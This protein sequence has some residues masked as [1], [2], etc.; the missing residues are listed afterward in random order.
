M[1]VK[2]QGVLYGKIYQEF[3]AETQKEKYRQILSI[4]KTKPK[5]KILDVAC[6]PGF[7][8]KM[9]KGA[10]FTDNNVA[11][12][13]AFNGLRVLADA[14]ALPFRDKSF[15]TVL[16]IDFVHLMKKKK[17]LARVGKSLIVSAFCSEF[18]CKQ[19]LEWL[20]GSF[21][22]AEQEF[23]VKAKNEWD[24]VIVI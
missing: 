9:L 8:S 23:L 4:A 24:A 18:N 13:R 15:D 10:I 17:E 14:N 16:C 2:Q 22:K 7:G 3:M 6:G 12:L 11:Y 5:G 19:K 20:K 21:G 1:A